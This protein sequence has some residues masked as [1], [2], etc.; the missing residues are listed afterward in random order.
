[1][2]NFN[3]LYRLQSQTKEQFESFVDNLE[4]N[5]NIITAK[6]WN[7]KVSL[8]DFIAHT[9]SWYEP[10]KTP[11]KGIKTDGVTFQLGLQQLICQPTH[12][13]TETSFCLDLIFPLQLILMMESS[14]HSS[15][16]QN[17]HHQIILKNLIWKCIIHTL[18][19]QTSG[20]FKK[21][22]IDDI[23]KA[24]NDLEW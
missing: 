21:T 8:G 6:I 17:C 19:N 24:M 18:M 12:T 4:L 2:C 22:N 14:V 3:S 7:L 13:F 11:Y 10:R 15:L 20:M 9:K 16:H 5:L 1:M 23:K